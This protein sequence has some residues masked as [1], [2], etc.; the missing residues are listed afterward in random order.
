MEPPNEALSD[1]ASMTDVS[2]ILNR[3][4]SFTEEPEVNRI[5]KIL[6]ILIGILLFLGFINFI[7]ILHAYTTTDA[8]H[9]QLPNSS[10]QL[11]SILI[12]IFYYGFGLLVTY[13]Y[14]QTGLLVVCNHHL[15]TITNIL[16]FFLFSS[17]G[18]VQ[19]HFY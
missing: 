19:Y 6:L 14:Y 15:I 1:K 9:S 7:F 12:S 8:L 13:R 10:S 11:V 18:S 3:S 4:V 17:L 2:T 16:C 5:R